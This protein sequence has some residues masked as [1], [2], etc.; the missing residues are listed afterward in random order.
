MS[1][2]DGATAANTEILGDAPARAVGNS[3]EAS[4]GTLD[5]DTTVTPDGADLAT[6]QADETQG[7]ADIYAEDAPK[8]PQ[9]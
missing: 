8:L 6:M 7:L 9:E 4:G 3:F 2:S 5:P 1:N